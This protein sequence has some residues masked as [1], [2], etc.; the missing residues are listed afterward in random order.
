MF[1]TTLIRKIH[2]LIAA[3]YYAKFV[4]EVAHTTPCFLIYIES[5]EKLHE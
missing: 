5:V 2:H 3:E 4:L 1:V